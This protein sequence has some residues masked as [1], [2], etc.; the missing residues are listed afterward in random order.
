MKPL[1]RAWYSFQVLVY[2]VSQ[3]VWGSVDNVARTLRSGHAPSMIVQMPLR[4]RTDVEVFLV[5]TLIGATPDSF[6]IGT[7]GAMPGSPH[8]DQPATLFVHVVGV[9]S[10]EEAMADLHDLEV[11]VLRATRGIR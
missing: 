6:V 9:E 3:L 4:A 8:G 5:S 11:R 10:R 2:L 1:R 7:A